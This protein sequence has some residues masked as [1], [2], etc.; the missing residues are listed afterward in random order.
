MEERTSKKARI[1]SEDNVESTSA[2]LTGMGKLFFSTQCDDF[3]ML[4]TLSLRRRNGTCF[5]IGE[6]SS[7][8]DYLV[9]Q[10]TQTENNFL[11]KI[12]KI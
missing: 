5:A 6:R 11:N 2:C 12:L 4:A 9:V 1:F 3:I 7:L 10:D 8:M